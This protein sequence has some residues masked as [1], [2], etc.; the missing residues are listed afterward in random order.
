MFIFYPNILYFI[1]LDNT[2]NE[3][4]ISSIKH[5][6]SSSNCLS[7]SLSQNDNSSNAI[8]LL[9]FSP[10]PVDCLKD[11]PSSLPLETNVEQNNNT[12]N[13][14]LKQKEQLATTLSTNNSIEHLQSSRLVNSASIISNHQDIDSMPISSIGYMVARYDGINKNINSNN[15]LTPFKNFN[16]IEK[17]NQ[18]KTTQKEIDN[19]SFETKQLPKNQFEI[20][21]SVESKLHPTFIK[22]VFFFCLN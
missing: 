12:E 9:P 6:S 5:Y 21:R 20:T 13:S 22:S 14:N 4:I 11:M 15:L 3:G 10:K 2:E 19:K 1:L 17:K 8:T 7:A 16:I 18:L